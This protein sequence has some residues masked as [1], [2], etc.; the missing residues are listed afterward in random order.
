ME[1]LTAIAYV[2][3]MFCRF[4][5]LLA[6]LATVVVSPAVSAHATGMSVSQDH[7]MHV[8][9]ALHASAGDEASCD[10]DRHCGPFQVETC[11]FVC[12]GLSAVLAS[13]G[14]EAA[15]A[16][17][18]ASHDLVSEACHIGR[19]PGLNERPPKPRLL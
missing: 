13:S 3:F 2:Y 17:S 16:V 5:A 9:E 1:M 11:E 15:P 19:A 7:V 8:G 6:I 10:G 12:A 18:P 14:T 4:I